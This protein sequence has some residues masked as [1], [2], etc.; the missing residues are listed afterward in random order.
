MISSAVD[1]NGWYS[2]RQGAY[3]YKTVTGNFVIEVSARVGRADDVNAQPSGTFKEAGIIIHN[4]AGP[5]RQNGS[6]TTAV[7]AV[8]QQNWVMY[9]IGQQVFQPGRQAKT[10]RSG[11][12]DTL[13]TL[14]FTDTAGGVR[15]GRIRVCRVGST[16]YFYHWLDNETGWAEEVFES[17]TGIEGNGR[18][19]ATPGISSNAVGN[20]IRFV[21][22]DFPSTL[23]VGLIAGN[24]DSPF[25]GRSDFDYARFA[26]VS[27]QS[28]CTLDLPAATAG[29]SSSAPLPVVPS[30]GDEFSDASTLS[31]WLN[32]QTVEGTA[33]QISSLTINTT[34]PGSLTLIP[35]Q[36]VAWYN[37]SLGS[38]L[39]KNISGDFVVTTHVSA[40]ALNSTTQAPS[41]ISNAA[42]LLVRVPGTASTNQNWITNNVGLHAGSIVGVT[43]VN[44]VNSISDPVVAQQAS[45]ATALRICRIGSTIRTYLSQDNEQTW[46]ETNV[47]TRADFSTIVQVG[48]MAVAASSPAD[49]RA[50]FDYI[51]AGVPS[52]QADCTGVIS[53]ASSSGGSSP[54]SS[55]TPSPTPAASVTAISG[56]GDEFTDSNTLS[57]WSNRQTIEGTGAQI[58]TWDI[59]MTSPGNMALAPAGGNVAWYNTSVG[60][61]I[62]KNIT[63]DFVVSTQVSAHSLT[64]LSQASG[65]Q[66]NAAGLLVRNPSSASGIQ[67]WVTNN[68]GTADPGVVGTTNLSTVNGATNAVIAQQGPFSA[69]LR[70][71]RIG[72]T[73]RTYVSAD[74]G[75]TWTLSNTISRT[76]FP[77]TL[78][79]GMMVV[80]AAGSND[81]RADFSFIRAGTP[82]S[83]SDCIGTLAPAVTVAPPPP[84]L[85]P[86]PTPSPTPT[87][88][89]S[90]QTLTSVAGYSDDFSSASTLTNWSNRQTVEGSANQIATWNINSTLGGNMVLVP[91]SNNIAWY[92][93]SVGPFIYKDIT[94]NFVVSTRLS[95]HS[96]GNPQ[97]APGS[98]YNA[99]GLLARDPASAGSANQNWV[100]LALGNHFSA[101]GLANLNTINSGDASITPVAGSTINVSLRL[102]RVGSTFQAYIS[103]DNEQTWSLR[104]TFTRADLPNTLQVGMSV[105]AANANGIPDIQA[106]FDYI[107]GAVPT[108]VADCTATISV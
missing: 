30:F 21:R 53:P 8:G 33:N 56:Y 72:S 104:D 70:I 20:P 10:T 12:P 7:S 31:Q 80:A 84:A 79:V 1:Q 65:Q 50:D 46:V 62:Y 93:A 96:V 75:Q 89:P 71:C 54:T 36:N 90:S 43:N 101:N 2:D 14:Y 74:S 3:L 15:S 16:I 91:S 52:N 44:T 77:T 60:P 13:S 27:A 47:V 57:Q 69:T 9:N 92:S 51:R 48:L 64:S 22:T 87:P 55:P 103:T 45:Y 17:T 39:Y 108:S 42:G 97:S 40:H 58:A 32:R 78:Q 28:D 19:L 24:W 94:G 76:D 106:D 25:N 11:T 49:I 66:Y 88:S 81:M 6:A 18:M 67:N 99:A 5:V 86:S 29:A 63:G 4:P 83:V 26:T 102:C 61:F 85:S 41:Q 98:I 68:V 37:T 35:S 38:F 107:R 73:I 23:Q 34:V 59:N 82:T 105:V 100:E 95:A